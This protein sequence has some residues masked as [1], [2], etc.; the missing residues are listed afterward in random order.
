[1]E[2]LMMLCLKYVFY[3]LCILLMQMVFK[4]QKLNSFFYSGTVDLKL[5][6]IGSNVPIHNLIVTRSFAFSTV[7]S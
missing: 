7:I 4:H 2:N 3:V 1:M 6:N 5:E